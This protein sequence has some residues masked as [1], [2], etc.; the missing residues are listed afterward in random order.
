MNKNEWIDLVR[1][2]LMGHLMNKSSSPNKSTYILAEAMKM[3]MGPL[4]KFCKV[5]SDYAE[6]A[7]Q[8]VE[9]REFPTR[10]RPEWTKGGEG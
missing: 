4:N 10:P 9:W 2:V 1:L 5:P 6:Q 8:W 7:I 3:G